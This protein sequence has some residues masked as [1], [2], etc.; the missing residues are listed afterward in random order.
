MVAQAAGLW[1]RVLADSYEIDGSA[2]AQT[3]SSRNESRFNS[4]DRGLRP[5]RRRKGQI[6][7]MLASGASH[8]AAAR[9]SGSGFAALAA[10]APSFARKA[11][12]QDQPATL[13][14]LPWKK[15]VF[16]MR[17]LQSLAVPQPNLGDRGN[18]FESY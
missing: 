17:M 9:G 11:E 8:P 15:R 13:H 1:S 12:L 16:K 18:E 2:V 5:Q 10:L 6:L 3:E 4:E 14:P 7:A